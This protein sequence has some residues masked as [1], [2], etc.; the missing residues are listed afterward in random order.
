MLVAKVVC[1][2][3]RVA[4]W[5][6]RVACWGAKVACCGNRV[7]CWELGWRVGWHDVEQMWHVEEPGRHFRS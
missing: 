2:G 6:A 7:A 1:W 5:E 4:Y 3:A